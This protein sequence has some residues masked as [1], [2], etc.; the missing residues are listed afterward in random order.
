VNKK[1][2]FLSLD[3][4][5]V[6]TDGGVYL[7]ENGDLFKKFNVKDGVGIRQAVKAGIHVAFISAGKS[8]RLL[9]AR[10]KML[11]VKFVYA[12]DE[13]KLTVLNKWCSKLKIGLDEV[14]HVADDI[15]DI[16]LLSAVGLPACP[17]DSVEKVKKIA[18]VI[19][20]K[21]GGE[22]CVREFIDNY[23]L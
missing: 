3:V 11:G 5:G 23:I 7:T 13:E 17:A 8:K 4:D 21:N 1:I 14:A 19:L 15:N 6:L 22:G 18:K 16:N 10:A 9:N 12:G 2:K 20:K